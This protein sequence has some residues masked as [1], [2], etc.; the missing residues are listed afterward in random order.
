MSRAI[1]IERLA[2]AIAAVRLPNP[3]RFAIDGVDGVGKTTLADELVAPLS[4]TGREVI[5][6]SIDGF[7]RPRAARYERGTLS[8]EGYFLDSFDY[9]ALTAAI[10][11][12][13]GPGGTRHFRAAVFDYRTDRPVE[14]TPRTAAPDAIL[15]FDGVF[16][17]RPEIARSWDLRIWVEAPF[18]VTVSRAVERAALGGEPRDVVR[19][20]YAGRYVPGQQ[21]YLDQCHPRESAHVFVDNTRLEHPRLHVRPVISPL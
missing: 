6:A 15:L 12:P 11:D 17:Q 14:T 16:L 4:R 10:L 21:I 5:R 9:A 19:A 2:A 13:L 20:Q 1:C 8:P 7:H 3:T 18:E